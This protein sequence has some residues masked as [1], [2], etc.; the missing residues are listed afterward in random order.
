M[1]PWFLAFLALTACAAAQELETPGPSPT[2]SVGCEPHGDHWHC[3][4]PATSTDALSESTSE[5]LPPSPTESIGCE[6]HDDHWHCDAPA[7]TT[8][9]D[10]SS[11]STDIEITKSDSA[12]LPPSPTESV[13]CEPHEDHWHCDGPAETGS[14]SSDNDHSTTTTATQEVGAEETGSEEPENA[15]GMLSVKITG[16]VA[17]A[18]GAAA[19]LLQLDRA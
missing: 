17:V 15:A 6:A 4:A 7:T 3:D 8:G 9:S 18:I 14:T 19:V 12:T 1:K 13:G 5:T 11:T 16:V 10:A 2:E